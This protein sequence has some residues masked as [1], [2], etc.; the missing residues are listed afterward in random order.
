M[1]IVWDD[2][3][4]YRFLTRG[5]YLGA[6][7]I[8][9]FDYTMSNV[10]S[11][12]EGVS[13]VVAAFKAAVVDYVLAIQSAEYELDDILVMNLGVPSQGTF[14]VA[15]PDTGGINKVTYPPGASALAYKYRLITTTGISRS[16]WKR[17]VGIPAPSVIGNAIQDYP[18]GLLDSINDVQSALISGWV[19]PAGNS[20][21]L[22]VTVKDFPTGTQTYPVIQ[23]VFAGIGTQNTRKPNAGN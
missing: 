14:V 18:E 2:N 5:R 7:I 23:C 6:Q 8:N 16:G 15:T 22:G 13:T 3:F 20:F 12:N 17:F 19:T 9:R 21:N 4:G 11:A 10:G 1:S